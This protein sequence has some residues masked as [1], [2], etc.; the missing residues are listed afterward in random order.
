MWRTAV[1]VCAGLSPILAAN[2]AMASDCEVLDKAMSE[3]V[4]DRNRYTGQSPKEILDYMTHA[5]AE[6]Q[7]LTPVEWYPDKKEA[8]DHRELTAWAAPMKWSPRAMAALTDLGKPLYWFDLRVKYDRMIVASR[9]DSTGDTCGQIQTFTL[10]RAR[11]L[12]EAAGP[13]RDCAGM[14]VDLLRFPEIGNFILTQSSEPRRDADGL[15]IFDW[16]FAGAELANE[17]IKCDYAIAIKTTTSLTKRQVAGRRDIVMGAMIMPD[18]SWND[19]AIVGWLEQHAAD[20]AER[21]PVSAAMKEPAFVA[22]TKNCWVEDALP[23]ADAER[24]VFTAAGDLFGIR[25]ADLAPSQVNNDTVT[26]DGTVYLLV[27]WAASEFVGITA[28]RLNAAGTEA[29]IAAAASFDLAEE[30]V[31][32]E[33]IAKQF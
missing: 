5:D 32:I 6:R 16:H 17:F 27:T 7:R 18:P 11:N 19:E 29:S 21:L 20:L 12:V 10:D 8:A 24:R 3:L 25:C 13:A 1:L 15:Q 33:L 2:P 22:S 28:H 23:R 31:A 26:L 9:T 14:Q 4:A 30:A